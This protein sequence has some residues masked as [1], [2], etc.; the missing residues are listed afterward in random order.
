MTRAA[1]LDCRSHYV[2][3]FESLSWLVRCELLCFVLITHL[4]STVIG[5]RYRACE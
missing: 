2:T 3:L 4:A 1:A 5:H